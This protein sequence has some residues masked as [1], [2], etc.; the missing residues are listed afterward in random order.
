MILIYK[1]MDRKITSKM[2]FSRRSFIGS[3]AAATLLPK[4]ALASEEPLA[5]V[6]TTGMIGD[7]ARIIGGA[8]VSVSTLMSSGVDPHGYRATRTDIVAL[9]RAEL[10]LWNGLFLEAQLDSLMHRLAKKKTVVPVGE[11][12]PE[13]LRLSHADYTGK[14]DP[15]VWMVP[16][17]WVFAIQA[18]RDAL[19]AARPQHAAV[20][21]ERAEAYLA[22]VSRLQNYA[23]QALSSVPEKARVLVTAHDAFSYF[24]RA[25]DYEV[26]GIQGI[27]T[28]SE[29]GLD[30]IRSLVD[31]LVSRKIA[32]VFVETSVSDRNMRALVEGAGQQGHAVRIGGE[33]FSDAM[34]PD[35]TYEATYL[36]MIDHNVTVIANALGANLPAGGM[37]GKLAAGI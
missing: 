30:R 20:F 29:A 5:V 35:G 11:A 25:F 27:S 18:T 36:G 24:G 28:E 3:V 34:G 22:D 21:S 15:H 10:I 9:S 26:L 33:L 23:E 37:D 32:A 13:D 12:V 17:I 7:A 8:E 6:A 16:R 19:I 14:P 1:T 2:A 31:T 4:T